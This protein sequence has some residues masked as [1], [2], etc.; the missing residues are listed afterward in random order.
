MNIILNIG[1]VN[2]NS[3]SFYNPIKNKF[4]K[5][6]KF[7]KIIYNC[8]DYTINTLIIFIPLYETYYIDKDKKIL[9]FSNK[10][11]DKL[12]IL[13]TE[14]LKKLTCFNKNYRLILDLSHN[15]LISKLN[16]KH[17]T[18][19]IYGIWN[20]DLDVGLVYRFIY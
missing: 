17:I 1:D 4:K 13:E 11:I 16:I 6:E 7:Y 18:L 10:I 15:N 14:T 3:I 9:S 8:N 20:N 19:R 12:K 5:Y 2:T